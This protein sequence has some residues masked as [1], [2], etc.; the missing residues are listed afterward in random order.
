M[1]MLVPTLHRRSLPLASRPRRTTLE[2]ELRLSTCLKRM[3]P[4]AHTAAPPCLGEGGGASLLE[5]G[6]GAECMHLSLPLRPRSAAHL[7][8]RPLDG[9]RSWG[10]RRLCGTQTE[11]LRRPDGAPTSVFVAA[12]APP[13]GPSVR[14]RRPAA[15]QRTRE[16]TVGDV[17]A[18]HVRT[19]CD[20]RLELHPQPPR[21]QHRHV[22][23]TVRT[24]CCAADG[25]VAAL[26][27]S[28]PGRPAARQA[29]R[30]MKGLR[31]RTQRAPRR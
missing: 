3:P 29:A 13:P 23:F 12:P 7:R 17:L 10:A 16:A 18:A 6:P 22:L 2:N 28:C 11:R 20:R 21:A 27:H 15:D 9:A 19:L 31:D 26:R 24:K 14:L 30:P 8:T 5:R 1:Y 4:F 25:G